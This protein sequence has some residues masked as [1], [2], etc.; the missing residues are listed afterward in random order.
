MTIWTLLVVALVVVVLVGVAHTHARVVARGIGSVS[1]RVGRRRIGGSTLYASLVL[2]R[3]GRSTTNGAKRTEAIRVHSLATSV[4]QRIVGG[5]GVGSAS[6]RVRCV[7]AARVA[8]AVGVGHTAGKGGGGLAVRA[9]RGVAPS[10]V[11]ARVFGHLGSHSNCGESGIV[12]GVEAILLD[13]LPSL[14]LVVLASLAF[15]P[16]DNTSQD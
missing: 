4:H 3:V 5:F 10:S 12:V 15:P 8:V 11:T 2:C 13:L 16:Q 6:R 7:V 9:G 1:G 14:L